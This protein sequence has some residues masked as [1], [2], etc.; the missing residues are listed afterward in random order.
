MK[1]I[2]TAELEAGLQNFH[3]TSQYYKSTFF[4][5]RHTDGVQYLAE[6]AGAYWL[7]DAVF[8]YQ[9]KEAFQVWTLDVKTDAVGRK[10]ATL[11][12]REDKDAPV[13]VKQEIEYTDFPL[14]SMELW[15]IDG[16]LILPS[17]Y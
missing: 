15:L 11:T 2:D 3:G 4:G 8:S 17:E 14:A 5:G 13:L 12:M 6:K 7:I 9:R 1:T 16:V 10:S